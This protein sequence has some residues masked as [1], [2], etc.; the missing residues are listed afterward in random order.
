MLRNDLISVKYKTMDLAVFAHAARHVLDGQPLFSASFSKGLAYPLPFIYPPFAAVVL[1]P[2]ALVSEPV[3]RWCWDLA[4]VAALVTVVA[5]SFRAL[6]DRAGTYWILVVAAISVAM[7]FTQP[8][9]DE[10]GYGQIDIFLLLLVVVDLL[11][12]PRWCP[13]GILIG[14]AAGVKLVPLVFVLLF[15]VTLQWR[16]VRNILATFV[17]CT[18]VG[19]VVVPKDSITFWFHE[20]EGTALHW[21]I[22]N[23]SNQSL[24]G[25][26]HRLVPGGLWSVVWI[27]LAVLLAVVSLWG[28]RSAELAGERFVAVALTSIVGLLIAPISWVHELVFIVPILGAI[29]GSATQ[30]VRLELTSLIWVLFSLP[31]Q[32]PYRGLALYTDHGSRLVSGLLED[33]YGIVLTVMLV[34]GSR[35]ALSMCGTRAGSSRAERA[36]DL[37]ERARRSSPRPRLST[38]RS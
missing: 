13:P 16:T 10:L 21:R 11:R 35:W 8:V 17:G 5:I 2:L 31:L 9:S 28:A 23:F 18:L 32:L 26:L 33:S 25:M 34:V 27:P 36:A 3:L 15:V 37:D 14:I 29:V 19:F 20:M 7:V 38:Q 30:R 22:A 12:R 6:K 1:T 24:D 4:S